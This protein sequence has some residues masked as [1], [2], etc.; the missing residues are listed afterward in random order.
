MADHGKKYFGNGPAVFR[1]GV[2]ALAE[3]GAGSGV[4]GATIFK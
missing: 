2:A 4:A 3:I 1:S